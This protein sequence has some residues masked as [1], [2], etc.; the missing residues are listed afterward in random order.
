MVILGGGIAG[1]NAAATLR[2]EGYQG[3]VVLISREPT[4][5]FGRPPLSKT[6]L[7]SEEELDG[8][9]VRPA[10]WYDDDDVERLE[11]EV[12]AVDPAAHTVTMQSGEDVEYQKILIATGGRNRNFDVPGAELPGIHQLRTVSECDAI[13]NEAVAGGRAVVVGMSFIGCEVAAS[14]T[15]LGVRVTAAF[16]GSAPLERVLGKELGGAFGA[17]HRANGVELLPDR[18]VSAFEGSDRVEAV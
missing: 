12:A 11:A 6:Y 1:G 10:D 16:P 18:H 3:R 17:F 8:W 4:V 15:Q 9:F 2:D 13:K 14:L 7:R 5:P